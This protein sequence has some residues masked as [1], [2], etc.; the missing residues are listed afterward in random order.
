ME[1]VRLM[2]PV[3]E[4][5]LPFG[6]THAD[7]IM[8]VGSCFTENM[9][10]RLLDSGFNVFVN[11]FGILYNPLSM[12]D[13]VRRCLT[14]E[15]VGEECLTQRDGLWHSWLHHGAFSDAD[16][17]VCLNRCNATLHE[18]HLFMQKSDILVFTF[19]SAWLRELVE[20]DNGNA[21]KPI[22]VANCHKVPERRFRLRMASV[23]EVVGAWMPL[24]Q[25]LTGQGKRLLFTIS[26]VRHLA[27]GAHGN[28]VGKAVLLLALERM[29]KGLDSAKAA[30]FPAYEILVDELRDYRFYADDMAHPS[31]LAERIIWHRFQQSCMDDATIAECRRHEL[32]A[33]RGNHRPL[34]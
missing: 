33:R 9:G 17:A 22:V 1:G 20:D 27:Y 6:I 26:P 24:A 7:G 21:C 23:D 5:P 32:Q 4:E 19:G 28:Q 13:A 2:T 18:A 10:K 15:G 25:L 14:D 29:L 30:Y 3:A 16:K 34:H 31:P 11:P 12:A 8:L